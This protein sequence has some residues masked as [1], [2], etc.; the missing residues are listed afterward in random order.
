MSHDTGACSDQSC[1]SDRLLEWQ[2]IKIEEGHADVIE[3]ILHN[4]ELERSDVVLDLLNLYYRDPFPHFDS[5]DKMMHLRQVIRLAQ[6]LNSQATLD[7]ISET[8]QL[9]LLENRD[10]RNW[11]F[12]TFVLF[13]TM[14]NMQLC[15]AA[16]SKAR[17]LSWCAGLNPNPVRPLDDVVIGEHSFDTGTWP[18][19]LYCIVP[20]PFFSALSRAT[21]N[22]TRPLGSNTDWDAVAGRFL[23]AHTP[24][25]SALV[26]RSEKGSSSFQ[27]QLRNERASGLR[28]GGFSDRPAPGRVM[29]ACPATYTH[30]GI[31]G[32]N[33]GHP[34]FV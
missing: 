3:I 32:G 21:L 13:S 19:E 23:E 16:I 20:T 28:T 6:S 17:D 29:E 26:F 27:S 7:T 11:P 8:L 10:D 24:G 12:G 22:L 1:Y 4:E 14:D 5:W 34:N 9:R 31:E 15:S 25:Q 2:R 30:Q 33:G 18:T